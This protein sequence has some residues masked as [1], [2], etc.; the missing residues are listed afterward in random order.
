MQVTHA[1]TCEER[2]D[3]I[4]TM[5]SLWPEQCRR[6][7]VQGAISQRQQGRPPS[8]CIASFH[9]KREHEKRDETTLLILIRI[10]HLLTGTRIPRLSPAQSTLLLLPLRTPIDP[11][12]R[13]RSS[14]LAIAWKF[15]VG[16]TAS[17]G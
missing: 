17:D 2:L 16:I 14:E 6:L 10:P 15:T 5:N 4:D 7:P 1:M 11:V 13:R 9:P 3:I 12:L 8:E